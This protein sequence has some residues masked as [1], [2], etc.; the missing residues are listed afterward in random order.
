MSALPTQYLDDDDDR[1]CCESPTET[2]TRYNNGAAGRGD[3]R[4]ERLRRQWLVVQVN[5]RR[6]VIMPSFVVQA[7]GD[8]RMLLD[9]HCVDG[10]VELVERAEA[11]QLESVLDAYNAGTCS[12][13]GVGGPSEVCVIE[14]QRANWLYCSESGGTYSF[15]D[16]TCQCASERHQSNRCESLECGGN[17]ASLASTSP[18]AVDECVCFRGWAGAQCRQCAAAQSSSVR[19]LCVGLVAAN[20]GG[21]SAALRRHTHAL[22]L[23]ATTELSDRLDGSYYAADQP[24]RATDRLPGTDSLDCRCSSTPLGTASAAS[25]ADAASQALDYDATSDAAYALAAPAMRRDSTS[26]DPTPLPPTIPPPTIR[27]PTIRP[28]TFPPPTIPPPTTP[29][30][31]PTNAASTLSAR[32]NVVLA[33][34]C[35]GVAVLE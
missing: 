25:H 20:L 11:S 6:G 29:S 5:Q 2:A 22:R 21:E 16:D 7:A 18:N 32:L 8:A 27:P 13:S 14:Q 17:G 24:T 12:Q 1:V 23:V 26:I 31:T 30:P 3:P 15:D 35:I 28:P 10:F 33:T 34:M 19:Y 9:M 4:F